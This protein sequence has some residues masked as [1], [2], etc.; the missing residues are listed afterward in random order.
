MEGISKEKGAVVKGGNF[1]GHV[2]GKAESKNNIE[3]MIL[4]SG[5][6]KGE[7]F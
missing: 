7:G 4:E 5:L 6:K 3:A 2:E 1:T